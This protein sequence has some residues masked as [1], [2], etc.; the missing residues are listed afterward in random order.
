[1]RSAIA[2]ARAQGLVSAGPFR[3]PLAGKLLIRMMDAPP[4]I[5]F[6]VPRAYRPTP[7]LPVSEVLPAFPMYVVI[8]SLTLALHA[9]GIAGFEAG[10]ANALASPI[11]IRILAVVTAGVV[12]DTLFIGYAF[13]RLARLTGSRWL[14]GA[15]SVTASALLH[16]PYW[17][18]GPVL[19]YLVTGAI[20]V[21][22]FAWRRDQLA[23]IIGHVTVDGMGL[24]V[25]PW[26]AR[27][28]S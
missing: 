3:H 28:Q 24:V 5:R 27:A 6:R 11:G 1:M 7:N 21:G 4:R 9:A 15:L 25:M 20:A 19:A 8:P 22:F 23:N 13:T 16:L 10:M 14:A 17:G 18:V 12:E 26:L 2:K